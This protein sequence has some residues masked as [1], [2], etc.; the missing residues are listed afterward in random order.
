MLTRKAPF[1]I[2]SGQKRCY[3]LH[4]ESR[5]IRERTR[6]RKSQN[7]LPPC[8]TGSRREGQ[9]QGNEPEDLLL[10]LVHGDS[11]TA[12]GFCRWEGTS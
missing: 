12:T 9:E 4:R 11:L 10:P 1:A 5:E 2:L 7:L 6:R 3:E 8:A